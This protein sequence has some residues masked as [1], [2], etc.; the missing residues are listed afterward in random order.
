MNITNLIVVLGTY[1]DNHQ[2]QDNFLLLRW[3]GHM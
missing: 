3:Y 2:K 1:Y